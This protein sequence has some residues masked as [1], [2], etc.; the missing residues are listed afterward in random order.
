MSLRRRCHASQWGLPQLLTSPTNPRRP[1]R[2]RQVW[3]YRSGFTRFSAS[4]YSNDAFDA[5]V[6]LTNVAVQKTSSEY[7][8]DFGGKWELGRLKAYMTSKHGAAAVDKMFA[9]LQG[10]WGVGEGGEA[11]LM[12]T[13]HWS[14][15]WRVSLPA[16]PPCHSR[17][18]P[19]SRPHT[20][21]VILYS[22]FTVQKVLINDPHCFE[23]YGYDILI[24]D[25]L[26]PW[27]L[28]VNASP[29]MTASTRDDYDL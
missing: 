11:V 8:A 4:R 16:P 12:L 19:P 9:D 18:P 1:H 22:L 29:S 21:D 25:A 3:I 17:H 10:E 13:A 5:Y 28:E 14:P 23:L 6:H 15:A 2:R 24:D 20:A 7:N 26:K 27:L